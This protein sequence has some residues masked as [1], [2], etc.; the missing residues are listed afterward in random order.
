[1]MSPQWRRF[2]AFVAFTDAFAF[3]GVVLCQQGGVADGLAEDNF[4]LSSLAMLRHAQ[5]RSISAERNF[6]E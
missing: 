3:P 4:G 2:A 6:R 1:M 5:S